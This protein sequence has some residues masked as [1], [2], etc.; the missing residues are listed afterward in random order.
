MTLKILV[1][2]NTSPRIV[3]Q[4]ETQGHDASHVLDAL[5]GGVSDSEIISYARE[6]GYAILTHDDDFLDARQTTDVK[7]LYYSDDTLS[8][9]ELANQVT[10]LG[11]VVDANDDLARITALGDW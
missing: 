8:T 11:E 1:D 3:T 5:G 2:E 9:T 10:E 4:L 6:H 7:V